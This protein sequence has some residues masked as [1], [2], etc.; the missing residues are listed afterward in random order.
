MAERICD[1]IKG[2]FINDYWTAGYKAEVSFDTLLTPVIEEI[3]QTKFPAA[4]YVTKEFPILKRTINKGSGFSS[5]NTDYLFCD[6]CKFYFVELK[7]SMESIND[8]QSDNYE[9]IIECSNHNNPW[10]LDFIA[11]LNHNS[12]T[13]YGDSSYENNKIIQNLNFQERLREIF[14]LIIEN[15]SDRI[16]LKQNDNYQT[17]AIKWLK[18]RNK[19]YHLSG[20]YKTLF[21]AGQIL[22]FWENNGIHD[23]NPWKKIEIIYLVPSIPKEPNPRFKYLSFVEALKIIKDKKKKEEYCEFLNNIV[24]KIYNEEPA[25]DQN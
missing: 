12:P 15:D 19:G 1:L 7:T 16:Q 22:D 17:K 14:N 6:G 20:K 2:S 18:Y 4:K 23:K 21:Q 8:D 11:L 5:I 9:Q 3:I 25:S 24:N 13:G 10:G